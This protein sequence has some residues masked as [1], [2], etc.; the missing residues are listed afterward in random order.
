MEVVVEEVMS[1]EARLSGAKRRPLQRCWM[2]DEQELNVF[3]WAHT[4]LSTRQHA[5]VECTKGRVALSCLLNQRAPPTGR[6][7]LAGVLRAN[8]PCYVQGLSNSH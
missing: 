6:L 1:R 4:F 3:T 2:D 8:S 7:A 5:G